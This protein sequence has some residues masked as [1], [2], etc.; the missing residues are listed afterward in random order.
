[1]LDS[2]NA[3]LNEVF[4]VEAIMTPAE[5][6]FTWPAGDGASAP[7]SRPEAA[8]YDLVPIVRGHEIVGIWEKGAEKA[9]PLTPDW[10][11]SRDT[12]I[13]HLLRV[14]AEKECEG[15]LAL[16]G[17]MIVGLVTPADLNKL[18]V[19]AYLYNLIGGLEVGLARLLRQYFHGRVDD[20]L[21]LLREGSRKKVAGELEQTTAGN[22]GVAP[23]EYLHISDLL[24]VVSRE[25]QLRRMLGYPSRTQ[26]EKDHRGLVELRHV[27]MHP[28]RPLLQELPGDLQGQ[29]ERIQQARNLLR[30]LD[31][32]GL[33]RLRKGAVA[34]RMREV[35][36]FVDDDPAYLQWLDECPAGYVLNTTRSRNP[37]YMVLHTA[38]C[39]TIGRENRNV[40]PGGF[41]GRGYI[42]ICAP[43]I[44]ALRAWTRQQGRPGGSFSNLCGICRPQDGH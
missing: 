31:D 38:T 2:Y 3:L 42:K 27:V 11:V 9:V 34:E 44:P 36:E 17:Q 28:V 18:P 35:R 7:W 25:P 12:A 43:S 19:R 29:H 20:M 41:T 21:E 5:A 4:T 24:D 6:F 8:E 26:A 16:Y 14:F 32:L 40:T 13:P 15:L 37:N 22:A 23:V 10:F 30:T 1:M 39:R 33:S